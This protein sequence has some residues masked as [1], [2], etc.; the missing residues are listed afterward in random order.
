MLAHRGEG[1]G[2][3][4]NGIRLLGLSASLLAVGKSQVA[5]EC[6]LVRELAH[7]DNQN[8]KIV[9][10]LVAKPPIARWRAILAFI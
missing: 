9:E 7:I 4:W 10:T 2:G 3:R 6:T 1:G 5:P 8:P